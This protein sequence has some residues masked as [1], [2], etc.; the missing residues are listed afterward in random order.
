[1]HGFGGFVLVLCLV[2]EDRR[3][4]DEAKVY[5]KREEDCYT[6]KAQAYEEV[7]KIKNFFVTHLSNGP[8]SPAIRTGR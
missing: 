1:V 6:E 2:S 4:V 3:K 8:Y 5:R 7:H